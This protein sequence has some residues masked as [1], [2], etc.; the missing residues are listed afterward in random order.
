MNVDGIVVSAA[1]PAGHLDHALRLGADLGVPVVLM[2]SH[3]AR[4]ERAEAI[5]RSVDGATVEV[6]DLPEKIDANL[7]EFETSA[8]SEARLGSHGNLSG[9]R[10]LGLVFGRLAGWR[11]VLFLDDD[12][13]ALQPN[14]VRQAASALDHCAAVGMLAMDFPD[15][16]MVCHAYRLAGG[17]Q[18]VFVSGSALAVNLQRADTF[19]PEIYNEDWLFL[20]PHLDRRAVGSVGRVKQ[21]AYAPFKRVHRAA[22]QEF[23][24]VFAEGLIGYL[25]SARL[26]NLPTIRYWEAFLRSRAELISWA[27]RRCSERLADDAEAEDAS[28]ALRAAKEA[29]D[30]IS[31]AALRRYAAAWVRDLATWRSYLAELPSLGNLTDSLNFLELSTVSVHVRSP[32][33]TQEAGETAGGQAPRRPAPTQRSCTE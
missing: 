25:H 30:E 32:L 29:L 22:E 6:V 31:A 3:D 19:F 12:I 4:V 14:V 1:R 26:K 10:N 13:R 8:F 21:L 33:R 15:N 2:C 17:R 24:D 9:K 11:A 16:S 5:A 7:P 20:A 27:L 28:S 23:G 18:D